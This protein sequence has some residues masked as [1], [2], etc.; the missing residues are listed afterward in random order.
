MGGKIVTSS[1]KDVLNHSRCSGSFSLSPG[2][3]GRG[4]PAHPQ[5]A[6]RQGRGE[7]LN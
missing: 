1:E 6:D 5:V 7:V 4:E 2:G 3:K